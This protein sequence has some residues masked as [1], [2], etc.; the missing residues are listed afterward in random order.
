MLLVACGLVVLDILSATGGKPP[1]IE[2]LERFIRVVAALVLAAA[3][4]VGV[5]GVVLHNHGIRVTETS[6]D[7]YVVQLIQEHAKVSSTSL[8][9]YSN[10]SLGNWL[11]PGVD[12]I[13]KLFDTCITFF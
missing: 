3:C 2:R 1:L 5:L 12:A 7:A 4:A 8:N 11:C 13:D 6:T 9:P 10:Q